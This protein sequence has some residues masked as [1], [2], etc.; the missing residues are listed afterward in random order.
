MTAPLLLPLACNMVLY[1]YRPSSG[2]RLAERRS[3]PEQS[4]MVSMLL[5][6]KGHPALLYGPSSLC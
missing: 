2:K 4:A 3:A 1:M 6:K 5:A